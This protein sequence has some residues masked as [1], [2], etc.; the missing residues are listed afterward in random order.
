MT[1]LNAPELTNSSMDGD[2]DGT[3]TADDCDDN[4]AMSTIVAD[5]M[6]CDGLLP[7]ADGG[8]DCDDD[9]CCCWCNKT[10]MVT[11][12]LLVM[13]TVMTQ[14]QTCTLVLHS[15]KR[16]LTLCV[17]DADGDGYANYRRLGVA[18]VVSISKMIDSFGDGWNGNAN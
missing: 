13:V 15:T 2:C 8:T 3:L 18:S 11:A 12:S 5:D 4:D 14:M 16:T 7:V 1:T 9:G 6:D 17:A 10:M